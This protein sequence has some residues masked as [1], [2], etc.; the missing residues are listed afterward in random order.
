MPPFFLTRQAILRVIAARCRHP[1]ARH[2]SICIVVLES[3]PPDVDISGGEGAVNFGEVPLSVQGGGNGVARPGTSCN[4]YVSVFV[5]LSLASRARAILT[6][7]PSRLS[8]PDF[9]T[10]SLSD[11]GIVVGPEGGV[12]VVNAVRL[13]VLEVRKGVH[14]N[15]VDSLDYGDHPTGGVDKGIVRIHV[16]DWLTLQWRPY[17][18]GP[19]MVHV[20]GNTLWRDPGTSAR[21]YTKICHAIYVLT[22]NRDADDEID[23]GRPILCRGCKDGVDFLLKIGFAGGPDAEEEGSVCIYGGCERLYGVSAASLQGC[24]QTSRCKGAV[25]AWQIAD[26]LELILEGGLITNRAG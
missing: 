1:E 14:A 18:G 25:R 5:G 8:D 22:A 21:S 2:A 3:V 11:Y 12:A 26:G 15:E 24:V 17:K 13:S 23:K 10:A 20:V 19:H 7:R 16:P 4:K 6:G 9:L